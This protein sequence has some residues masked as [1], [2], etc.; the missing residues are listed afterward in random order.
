ML[1]GKRMTGDPLDTPPE[2]GQH[3]SNGTQPQEQQVDLEK[4]AEKVVEKLLFELAIEN[5]RMGITS[6]G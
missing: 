3:D 4:L 1:E 6:G 2:E 5:E